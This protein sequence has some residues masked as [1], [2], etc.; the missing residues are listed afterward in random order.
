MSEKGSLGPTCPAD[1][2]ALNLHA[3]VFSHLTGGEGISSDS[4]VD[5]VLTDVLTCPVC[6]YTDGRV[7]GSASPPAH[8]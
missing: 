1:G 3:V 5:G 2:A 4:P 8:P 7:R 6:G